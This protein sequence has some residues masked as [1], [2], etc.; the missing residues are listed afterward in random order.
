VQVPIREM[1]HLAALPNIVATAKPYS[2]VSL[3][4]VP[5]YVTAMQDENVRLAMQ[6]SIDKAALS[7]A[8]FNNVALP[9]SVLATS[10]TPGYV[11][12]FTAP[13]DKARAIDL[14]KKSGYGPD[15]PIHFPFLATNGAFPND[16][17]VARALVSMWKAVGIQ[18]DIQEVPL[19]KYVDLNHSAALPGPA[20]YSWANPTG[21]PENYTGRI[22]DSTGPFSAWK[23]PEVGERVH[24]LMVETDETKRIDGYQALNRDATDH[25]WAIPLYQTVFT[26][27][28]KKGLSVVPYQGGYIMPAD[29]SWAP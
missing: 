16:F 25:A 27:A 5:S 10:Q 29:Y 26:L 21:D 1:T 9:T 20:L 8:F 14:L 13:Y 12:G 7:K 23:N 17:D 6:L 28:Y 24:A 3:V 19:A 4:M 22:L 18:A 2:E 15:K 11:E